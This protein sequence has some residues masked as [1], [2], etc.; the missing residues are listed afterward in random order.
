[1]TNRG[2][3]IYVVDG[4]CPKFRREETAEILGIDRETVMKLTDKRLL[5]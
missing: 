1:M 3:S 2:E 4:N 5:G